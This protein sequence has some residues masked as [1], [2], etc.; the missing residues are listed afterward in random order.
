MLR[1][2]ELQ[3]RNVGSCDEGRWMNPYRCTRV[4]TVKA[5]AEGAWQRSKRRFDENLVGWFDPR[6]IDSERKG[7]ARGGQ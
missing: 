4:S 2:R 5:E 7:Y 1:Q 6:K 3:V